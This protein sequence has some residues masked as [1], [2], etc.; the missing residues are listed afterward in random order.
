MDSSV[1]ALLAEAAWAAFEVLWLSDVVE[2]SVPPVERSKGRPGSASGGSPRF[3]PPPE[4]VDWN[5]VRR[6]EDDW[7]RDESAGRP[8]SGG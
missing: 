4:R 3:V 7:R 8:T 1:H 6:A 5:E 2:S